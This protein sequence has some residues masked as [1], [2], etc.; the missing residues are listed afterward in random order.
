MKWLKKLYARLFPEKQPPPEPT[1][2]YH[3]KRLH[4][5][6][7]VSGKTYKELY[8]MAR[9]YDVHINDLVDY[10]FFFGYLPKPDLAIVIRHIGVK[11]LIAQVENNMADLPVKH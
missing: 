5:T 8:A 10:Y 11:E 7:L 3:T 4:R 6:V 2:T 1:G 9:Q